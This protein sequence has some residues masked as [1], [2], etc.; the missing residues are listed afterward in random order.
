MAVIFYTSPLS[1]PALAQPSQVLVLTSPQH[2][3]SLLSFPP[4][5]PSK[6]ESV[7]HSQTQPTKLMTSKVLKV[8]HSSAFASNRDLQRS[9]KEGK[10]G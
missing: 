5:K 1:D 3:S 7:S 2:R 10:V 4:G 9:P 8:H 6:L